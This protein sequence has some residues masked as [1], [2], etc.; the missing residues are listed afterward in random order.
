MSVVADGHTSRVLDVMNRLSLSVLVASPAT[1]D[2]AL[3]LLRTINCQ[4]VPPRTVVLADRISKKAVRALLDARAAGILRRS[5]ARLHLPWAVQ[6]T[7]QG[8]L[9]LEPALASLLVDSYLEPL[10]RD[11]TQS[12]AESLLTRLTAREREVLTLLAD[13]YAAPEIAAMLSLATGTVK[14]HMRSVYDKLGVS[15]RI[16]AARV[17]WS[18]GSA[19]TPVP[20]HDANRSADNTFSRSA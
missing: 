3:R 12:E 13:G 17:F 8:A 19:P 14:S 20:R 15:N 11:Q 7:A 6:A 18:A 1:E 5:T 10:R 2:E 16:Q 9:A 4:P